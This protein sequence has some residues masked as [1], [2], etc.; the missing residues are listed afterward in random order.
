MT[1]LNGLSARFGSLRR[2]C[3]PIKRQAYGFRDD[4]YFILKIKGAFPGELQPNPR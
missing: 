2:V 1:G 3:R 4:G